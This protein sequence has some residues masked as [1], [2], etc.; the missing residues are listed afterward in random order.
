MQE[1]VNN[2]TYLDTSVGLGAGQKPGSVQGLM[3]PD[4][5]AANDFMLPNG[6]VLAQPLS[7]DTLSAA[8]PVPGKSP[9][10]TR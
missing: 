9:P 3:G 2:G 8:S 10:A 1:V 6:T 5:G 7:T 4:K